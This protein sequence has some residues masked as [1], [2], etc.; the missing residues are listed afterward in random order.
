LCDVRKSKSVLEIKLNS[1]QTEL[2]QAQQQHSNKIKILKNELDITRK[3]MQLE[4]DK[5][6]F[7]QVQLQQV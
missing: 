6:K 1:K 5:I 2:D 3:E 7:E 4:I